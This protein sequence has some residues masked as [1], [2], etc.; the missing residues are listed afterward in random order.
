MN[1]PETA[2]LLEIA[3]KDG[4]IDSLRAMVKSYRA[5]LLKAGIEP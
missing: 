5:K 4:E 2:Y 1:D 3:Q